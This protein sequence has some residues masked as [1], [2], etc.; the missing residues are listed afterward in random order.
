M[1]RSPPGRGDANASGPGGG[2]GECGRR[3]LALALAR[4]WGRII[5]R[6]GLRAVSA[7]ASVLLIVYGALNVLAAALVLSG[8]LH[9]TGRVD[10]PA[11]RWHAGVWDLWFLVWGI[12]LTLA[13]IGSRRRATPTGRPS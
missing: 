10:R 1:S 6:R 12:L 2:G 13:T 4:P 8:V 7:A 9:P 5:P 11:L 3:L